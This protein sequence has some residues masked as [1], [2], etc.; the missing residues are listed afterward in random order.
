MNDFIRRADAI[1]LG[2][3][4]KGVRES[5]L[6][7]SCCGPCSTAC[8]EY[9]A[10]AFDLTVLFYNPNIAPED[11]YALR[12]Q[13]LQRYIRDFTSG[14]KCEICDY[15]PQ[16]FYSVVKGFE[17]CPEGGA[18]CEKCFRLRLEY[19]ARVAAERGFDWFC[20]TLT[21]SPH[22]N[23]QLINAVGQS[24]AE[25]YGVKFFPSDF[26]K[27]DGYLKSVRLAKEAGLYRQNYCGCIFS[28]RENGTR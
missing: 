20:T 1:K 25:K 24:L 12:A 3:K 17:D 11:E 21:V 5:M 6:L 4:E 13:E 27:K 16:E 15:D 18:R 14:V 9:L 28:A 19:C 2:L 22:K 10:D 23:A 7:H 8:I 26:K